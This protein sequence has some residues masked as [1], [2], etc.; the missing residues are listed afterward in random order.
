MKIANVVERVVKMDQPVCPVLYRSFIQ[1]EFSLLIVRRMNDFLQQYPEMKDVVF[2]IMVYPS[3]KWVLSNER[4][5]GSLLQL[6]SDKNNAAI[7][8]QSKAVAEKIAG[9]SLSE[10][11][12]HRQSYIENCRAL[13]AGIENVIDKIGTYPDYGKKYQVVLRIALGIAEEDEKGLSRY[14]VNKYF[15]EALKL[16][17]CCLTEQS[18]TIDKVLTGALPSDE[19]NVVMCQG[20]LHILQEYTQVLWLSKNSKNESEVAAK[21]YLEFIDKAIERIKAF[22]SDGNVYYSIIQTIIRLK[23][24]GLPDEVAAERL[25]M[26]TYTFS[27]KKRRALLVFCSAIF[28]CE[29]DICLKLLADKV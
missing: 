11:I 13:V 9:M 20:V 22:P 18:L 23:P 8:N 14:N 27:I 6:L 12:K 10:L 2:V 15:D 7:F 29:G 21:K 17:Y 28:S 5:S 24:L 4:N 25:N 3:I 16:M 26:S 1:S 19:A